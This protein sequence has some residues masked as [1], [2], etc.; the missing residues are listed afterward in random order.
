MLE[1]VGRVALV[2]GASRGI[3]RAVAERLSGAG[4]RISAGLRDPRRAPAEWQA[5]RYDAEP[6]T[7]LVADRDERAGTEPI[8]FPML[9]SRS[10]AN[11][12]EV[13]A[14]RVEPN[15][16]PEARAGVE[17]RL[18]PDL[19]GFQPL[20]IG[21]SDGR[22]RAERHDPQEGESQLHCRSSS[23]GVRFASARS[24][25][26]R[27]SHHRSMRPRA[28]SSGRSN[29]MERETDRVVHSVCPPVVP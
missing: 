3:G 12:K 26:M 29:T 14:L 15:D 16:L 21:W 10:F 17:L 20:R 27:S 7:A 24:R 1:P 2:S 19:D 18:A 8:S 23:L 28:G 11:R 22:T 4:Y 13:V 25:Q 5:C 9:R 6:G